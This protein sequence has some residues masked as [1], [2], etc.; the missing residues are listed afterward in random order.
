MRSLIEDRKLIISEIIEDH[1]KPIK[2]FSTLIYHSNCLQIT[3]LPLYCF[4][5]V[6]FCHRNGKEH[7]SRSLLNLR[8]RWLVI[9]L[10]LAFR[11]AEESDS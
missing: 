9:A 5:Y 8:T 11:Q 4:V 2:Q 1:E 10:A 7:V 6:E 3:K